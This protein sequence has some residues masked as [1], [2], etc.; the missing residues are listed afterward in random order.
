MW[1]LSVHYRSYSLL[2]L[3]YMSQEV[4]LRK[5]GDYG[6]VHLIGGGYSVHGAREARARVWRVLCEIFWPSST[7]K[8]GVKQW[9]KPLDTAKNNKP[10]DNQLQL[11]SPTA[12][13]PS[14]SLTPQPINQPVV[15]SHPLESSPQVSFQYPPQPQYRHG[16]TF[17]AESNNF[18]PSSFNLSPSL[19][20]HHGTGIEKTFQHHKE[21]WDSF[22]PIQEP[23]ALLPWWRKQYE[24]PEAFQDDSCVLSMGKTVA[25]D[26]QFLSAVPRIRKGFHAD[27]QLMDEEQIEP[28]VKVN[29]ARYAVLLE[30]TRD[31]GASSPL[32]SPLM[33]I[34]RILVMLRGKIG[35]RVTKHRLTSITIGEDEDEARLPSVLFN[36][37]PQ[38]GDRQAAEELKIGGGKGEPAAN[39]EEAPREDGDGDG[40]EVLYGPY[41]IDRVEVAVEEE[42]K[43]GEMRVSRRSV[44]L[45]QVGTIFIKNNSIACRTVAI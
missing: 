15:A 7:F 5:K 27:G 26:R 32:N 19:P 22:N 4:P 9:V 29:A 21:S 38:Y 41:G 1:L 39:A 10:S 25:R 12:L 14:S 3:S 43:E 24:C 16:H 2:K 17:S 44:R 37:T 18:C 45:D 13:H 36:P 31:P 35:Q 8:W 28:S 23:V 42:D 33:I 11:S 20:T 30:A 6:Q 40:E 34:D